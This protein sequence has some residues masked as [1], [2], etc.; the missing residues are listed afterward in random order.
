MPESFRAS[1]PLRLLIASVVVVGAV[2]L[3]NV[4]V[5]PPD[6]IDLGRIF[7][8]TAIAL[9]LGAIPV[10]LPGGMLAFTTT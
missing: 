4:S 3:I 8:W 6:G 9:L 1:L 10:R 2:V 7:F 5:P